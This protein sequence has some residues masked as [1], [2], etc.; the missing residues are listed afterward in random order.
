MALLHAIL[1]AAPAWSQVKPFS[2]RVHLKVGLQCAGCHAA[3]LN[4]TK[5]SDN[6][7]PTERSCR[8]CHESVQ[9]K[10]PEQ[11][12]L[13]DFNHQLHLRLGNVAPLLAK[14]I[15]SGAYLAPHGDIRRHLQTNNAC[16]ACHRGLEESDS[17]SK[18]AFP[19]MAD[20]LVCHGK[21]DAPFSCEKC[22]QPGAHLKPADHVSDYVDRHSGGKLALD[23]K[24]CAI[25]HGRRFT[26]LG[27]H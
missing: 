14:A 23:K 17:V 6:N 9:I 16:A 22:H 26:C 1:A 19:H 11:T 21:I 15:S 13:K 20:C 10:E 27:C 25:C 2:H 3:A 24:S 8:N 18:A 12:L 4:S 7:L 5:A